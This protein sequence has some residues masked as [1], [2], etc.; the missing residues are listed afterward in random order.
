MKIL[1]IAT[2]GSLLALFSCTSGEKTIENT[3]NTEVVVQETVEN[4]TDKKMFLY[5]NDSTKVTWTAYKTTE[6]VGVGGQFTSIT[7]SN[8]IASEN[9]LDVVKEAKFTIPVLETITGNEQRD[10]RIVKFFFGM[11]TETE[12]ITGQVKSLNEDGTG[13]I[14]IVFNGIEQVLPITYTLDGLKIEVKG[15]MDLALWNAEKGIDALN[16]ECKDL[17]AGADGVTKLWPT[18]DIV[19]STVLKK[20]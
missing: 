19:I 10:N 1:T 6:K 2:V 8:V 7:V 20:G 17:H 11:L 4:T 18:V 5:N 15:T 14:A 13:S 9:P 3:K 16:K 12:N